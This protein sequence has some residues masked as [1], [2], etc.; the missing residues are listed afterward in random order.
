MTTSSAGIE[1]IA[2]SADTTVR[3]SF[4]CR[5]G[6]YRLHKNTSNSDVGVNF[7]GIASHCHS[8]MKVS[9]VLT[10]F[11]SERIGPIG[12]TILFHLS[13]CKGPSV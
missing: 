5:V 12:V 4:I 2:R 11:G 7:S 3:M 10:S 8:G 9:V 1:I 13:A 6:S